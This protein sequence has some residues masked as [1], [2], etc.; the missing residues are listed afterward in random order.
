MN[1][2][3]KL[4][5]IIMAAVTTCSVAAVP[6]SSNA[7]NYSWRKGGFSGGTCWTTTQTYCAYKSRPV[8]TFYSYYG[9][10][11]QSSGNTMQVELINA[12]TGYRIE[13]AYTVRSGSSYYLKGNATKYRIRIR[14]TARNSNAGNS[15]WWAMR[16]NTKHGVF[17]Y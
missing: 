13:S 15:T 4:A 1:I 11:K 5:A 2:K 8:I 17:S 9:N 7:A 12:N 10:G 16:S 3:K 14:R 6:M